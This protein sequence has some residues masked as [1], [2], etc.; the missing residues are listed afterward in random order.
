MRL[1][2]IDPLPQ[3]DVIYPLGLEP[4]PE[5]IPAGEVELEFDLP[6]TIAT[7]FA[8]VITSIG[9][10]LTL[11]EEEKELC[12]DHIKAL[13]YF[14][15]ARQLY[16]T[17]QDHEKSANQPLK[18][19]Y[20]DETPIPLHM[21]GALGIIG[22]MDTKVGQVLV[23]DAGLL[24]KRWI[25]AGLGYYDSTEFNADAR[26]LIWTDIDSYRHV[27]RAARSRIRDLVK[28][29]YTVT[30]GADTYVVSMPQLEQQDL[31]TYY[32]Q[33]NNNVPNA[34]DI[35]HCVAALEMR[36]SQFKSGEGIPHNIDRA[37]IFAS[38]NLVEAGP[39]YSFSMMRE[40]F[41]MF[42]SLYTTDVKWR[43]ESIFKTGPPPAGSTGYGAQTVASGS[44]NT[45]RWQFPLSDADVN[46]GYLFSPSREF[47]LYPR[48][49]GYAKRA[50][51]AA[52]A[53][54]AQQDAKPFAQ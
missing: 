50:R 48:M 35:R 2:W 36:Y 53:M 44:G 47:T 5:A 49:V 42:I 27:Q 29:T 18:A 12:S 21:A 22:H 32:R 17:M 7:P 28:Q 34:D 24:Y 37:D 40:M 20:Y 46:I 10:R 51:E 45:A 9:D 23:R 1:G 31:S 16:S 13:S 52:S 8:N 15:A 41:E 39:T 26:N 38:L 4:N 14:K 11:D 54:F 6:E 43:V 19:I 33:I 30:S 25:A 3:V